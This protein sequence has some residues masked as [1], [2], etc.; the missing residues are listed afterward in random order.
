MF[1]YVL[2]VKCSDATEQQSWI[3]CEENNV[4]NSKERAVEVLMKSVLVLMATY[5]GERYLSEQINSILVQEEVAVNILISD[6]CSTDKTAD[7]LRKYSSDYSNITVLH[8]PKNVG[9]IANFFSLIRYAAN[10]KERFDYYAFSDQDDY[11]L[12]NKLLSASSAL[13]NFDISQPLLYCSRQTNCDESLEPLYTDYYSQWS[14]KD[15]AYSNLVNLPSAYACTMVF[16]YELLYKMS[17]IPPTTRRWHDEWALVLASLFGKVCADENAYMLRR[18]HGDNVF[19]KK[20]TLSAKIQHRPFSWNR[21]P[22][23]SEAA[24]DLVNIFGSELGREDAKFI[25]GVATYRDKMTTRIRLALDK[26]IHG[27]SPKND[28]F[29][30]IKILFGRI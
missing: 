2:Q 22:V 8:S 11:W 16:N 26:R 28:A 13:D 23:F 1:S 3:A 9:G 25:S 4:K 15:Y 19:G 14:R 27:L 30:R 6:D 7:I 12:P 18:I 21:G 24:K 17:K 20:K 10:M 29:M 5:N